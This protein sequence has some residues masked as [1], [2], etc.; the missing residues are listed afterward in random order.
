MIVTRGKNGAVYK[1]KEFPAPIVEVHDVCGAGDT[2]LSV[3]AYAYLHYN[4]IEQAIYT[5]NNAAAISVQHSG[6]YVL[7]K[8]DIDQ[9]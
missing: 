1:Q 9:I 8:R 6:V 7:D 5:A 2:F 4:D 3:L